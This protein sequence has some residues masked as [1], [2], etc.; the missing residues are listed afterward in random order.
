MPLTAPELAALHGLGVPVVAAG[1]RAP[2]VH[3]V[4]INDTET[5][6]YAAEHLIGLGHHRIGMISTYAD[7]YLR[8]PVAQERRA[9][10]LRSLAAAGL[11]AD[12]SLVVSEPFGLTGGERAMNRLLR[13]P[14]LPTAVFAE[15]DE[16][17]FGALLALRKAGVPVPGG[18]SVVG[19]D[20]HELSAVLELTT[21]HQPVLEQG[22]LAARMLVRAMR[23]P[24]AGPH[25]TVLPTHLVVRASTGPPPS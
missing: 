17:A 23:E 14:D 3:S 12:D 5:T 16:M 7:Q 4:H 6:R 19:V 15:C 22:E 10:Y 9:S 13:L 21:V 20:D 24:V 11:P 1:H 25:E 8:L 18:M 2:G